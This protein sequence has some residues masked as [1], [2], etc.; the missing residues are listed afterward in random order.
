MGSAHQYTP[1]MEYVTYMV[2]IDTGNGQRR[3][4][5]NDVVPCPTTVNILEDFNCH[6]FASSAEI[7]KINGG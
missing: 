3:D 7:V 4:A 2:T 6:R 1:M 5:D